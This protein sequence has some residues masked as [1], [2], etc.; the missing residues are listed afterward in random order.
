MIKRSAKFQF[1]LS[2]GELYQMSNQTISLVERDINEFD[3]YGVNTSVLNQLVAKKEEFEYIPY[4]EVF[5]QKQM[6]L[7]QQKNEASG[8]LQT[9]IR[10]SMLKVNFAFRSNPL[11]GISFRNGGVS[12]FPDSELSVRARVTVLL[13]QDNLDILSN[14]GLSQTEI[15]ELNSLEKD[16]TNKLDLQQKAICNRD[17]ATEFRVA[18]ANELYELISS[19]R[20][21][22]RKMWAEKSEALSNDYIILSAKSSSNSLLENAA[23]PTTKGDETENE[24]LS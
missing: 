4:D 18:K 10:S 23:P 5:E 15:D 6:L 17:T 8:L 2:Y 16:F 13:L 22:G 3:K 9:A 1:R 11:V 21:V 14:Y 12:K 19:I 7:T 20:E 24:P